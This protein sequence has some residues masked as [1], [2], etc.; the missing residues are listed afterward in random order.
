MND[1]LPLTQPSDISSQHR[2]QSH[3]VLRICRCSLGS[4]FNHPNILRRLIEH[5]PSFLLR[6]SGAKKKSKKRKATKPDPEVARECASRSSGSR[7][8]KRPRRPG[9]R[10]SRRRGLPPEETLCHL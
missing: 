9:R 6:S 10:G 3:A 4:Q 2:S 7:P 1:V 8:K 5:F